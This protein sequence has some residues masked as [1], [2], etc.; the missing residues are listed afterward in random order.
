[1]DAKKFLT[2]NRN[3]VISFYN[4]EIVD[5]WNISLSSFMTD[6]L[7]NFKQIT[8]GDDLKKFDLFGNLQDAKKRLGLFEK[9][10]EYAIDK[11]TQDLRSKYNGTSAMALI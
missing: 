1:M 2:E 3:E 11:K 7:I 8:T 6:L 9:G 5:F 10:F 4:N